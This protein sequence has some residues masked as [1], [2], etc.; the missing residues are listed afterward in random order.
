MT[1]LKG[2][3]TTKTKL[4]QKLETLTSDIENFKS[5][6]KKTFTMMFK[7]PENAITEMEKEKETTEN[8][9]QFLGEIQKMAA[10]N[11]EWYVE[12]FKKEKTYEY[13][14][15][16]KCFVNLQRKNTVTIDELWKTVKNCMV[17]LE[18]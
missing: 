15:H 1:S 10:M 14:R 6:G 13:F 4:N 11:M 3:E 2:L 7:N 9:I 8:N 18:P 5:S 17:G 16:F 12:K